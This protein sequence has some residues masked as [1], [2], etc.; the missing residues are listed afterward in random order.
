MTIAK[1]I[2]AMTEYQKRI[3][4]IQK[5]FKKILHQQTA[6]GDFK[7]GF[8]TTTLGYLMQTLD[9]ELE[10]VEKTADQ[11]IRLYFEGYVLETEKALTVD[12]R[13]LTASIQDR[14]DEINK[15]IRKGRI[16]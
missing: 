10:A 12:A 15:A 4:S 9:W 3:I 14:I 6:T 5:Q 7:F 13:E 16:N 11:L 8:Y 1:S 2:E